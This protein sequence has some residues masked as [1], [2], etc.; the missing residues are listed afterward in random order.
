MAS[1]DTGLQPGHRFDHAI[2][3]EGETLRLSY[4]VREVSDDGRQAVL[5]IESARISSVRHIL[6]YPERDAGGPCAAKGCGKPIQPGQLY[7]PGKK[8]PTHLGC[9]R[10]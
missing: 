3:A 1:L 6:D 7:V 4:V 9:G 2:S 8:G 10:R 5:E